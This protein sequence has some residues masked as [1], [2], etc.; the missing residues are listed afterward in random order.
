MTLFLVLTTLTASATPDI[1]M[2]GNSYTQQQDLPARLQQLF[3]AAGQAAQVQGLTAGGL[4]LADHAERAQDPTSSWYTELETNAT[5]REWVVLQDQ[6]QIPG[7]PQSSPYWQDSV[8]GAEVLNQ[9]VEIAEA[10]TVFFMTWGRRDGDSQNSSLYPDFTTMQENLTEGYLAYMTAVATEDRP[11]WVA[12]VGLAFAHIHNALI[13][14]DEIP[15]E[16]GSAFHALYSGDGSHPSASGSYLAACVFYATLTGESPVGLSLPEEFEAEWGGYLQQVAAT[17]VFDET[18]TLLYP[19]ED[20][21]TPSEE[22]SG[23]DEEE[24]NKEEGNE[25]GTSQD[26][27]DPELDSGPAERSDGNDC[28][29]SARPHQRTDILVL[30]SLFGAIV[31]RRIGAY[32]DRL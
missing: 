3:E 2:L 4:T 5:E 15:T 6:S 9:Q 21:P 29:C 27:A 25:G 8:T 11:V 19:W 16:S 20:N 28:G 18:D 10:E 12:P 7:F 1:L 32:N 23:G 30:I 26:S 24:G 17:T 31:R 14:A 22:D 13:D